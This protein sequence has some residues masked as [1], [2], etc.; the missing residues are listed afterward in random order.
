MKTESPMLQR[1]LEITNKSHQSWLL[2]GHWGQANLG[3]ARIL[4]APIP[5]VPPLVVENGNFLRKNGNL[6]HKDKSN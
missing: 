6:G 1:I 5:A 4:R 3:N 2:I